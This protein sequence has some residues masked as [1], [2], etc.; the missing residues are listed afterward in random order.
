MK[1]SGFQPQSVSSAPGGAPIRPILPGKVSGE[2]MLD[3]ND[4][5]FVNGRVGAY[6]KM[7]RVRAVF[8]SQRPPEAWLFDL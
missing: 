6:G 7:F 4:E 5:S 2:S 3:V 1:I 8:P